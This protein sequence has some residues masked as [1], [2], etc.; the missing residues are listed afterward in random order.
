MVFVLVVKGYFLIVEELCIVKVLMFFLISYKEI[1]LDD[2][3][4]VLEFY[5]DDI[6]EI[7]EELLLGW[8]VLCVGVEFIFLLES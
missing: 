3:V 4:I 2:E 1:Y 5:C 6:L 8:E 7:D